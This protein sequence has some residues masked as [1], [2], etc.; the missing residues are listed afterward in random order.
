MVITPNKATTYSLVRIQLDCFV[1]AFTYKFFDKR[2][3]HKR[4]EQRMVEWKAVRINKVINYVSE[5]VDRDNFLISFFIIEL[6]QT[7]I[8]TE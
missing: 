3:E 5:C 2:A 7:S 4:N 8:K 6:P 1:V